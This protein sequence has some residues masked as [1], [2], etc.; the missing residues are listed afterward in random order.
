[1]GSQLKIL[2]EFADS[3]TISRLTILLEVA[4]R[5][6]PFAF[7]RFYLGDSNPSHRWEYEPIKL[8]FC[9]L[10]VDFA[11]LSPFTGLR[12]PCFRF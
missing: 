4:R 1:M 12:L 3:E 8:S 7:S 5:A 11:Q 6:Q 2:V 9:S 10:L